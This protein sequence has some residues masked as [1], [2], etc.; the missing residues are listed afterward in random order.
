MSHSDRLLALV[1]T[2]PV[3]MDALRAVRAVD[4]PDWL[5]CAGAI[6]DLVWDALH[7]RSPAIPRDID[8]GFFDPADA[9]PRARP[10]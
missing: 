10:R 3:L 2:S 7:D 5:V 8:A 9:R 6:R 1:R 4:P